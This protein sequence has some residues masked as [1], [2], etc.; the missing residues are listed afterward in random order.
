MLRQ[1]AVLIHR[2]RFEGVSVARAAR[3]IGMSRTTAYRWLKRFDDGSSDE[4]LF[5]RSR[6]PNNS[7]QRTPV[8][9]ERRI[10]DLHEQQGWPLAR[11]LSQLRT[12]GS[13][14]P[15]LST[16]RRILERHGRR[17]RRS[18]PKVARPWAELVRLLI[19]GTP[20]QDENPP[21]G[22]STSTNLEELVDIL[23]AG[24][25]RQRRRALVVLL[26]ALGVPRSAVVE[27]ARSSRQTVQRYRNEFRERGIQSIPKSCRRKASESRRSDCTRC[28]LWPPTLSPF[29]PRHQSH[30]LAYEGSEPH[31]AGTGYTCF[32]GT[33]SR[34]PPDWGL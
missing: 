4:A 13:P 32:N 6:R 12:E 16:A 19:W 14:A 10:L 9:I 3:E 34:N 8:R 2:V 25:V 1:R 24:G 26:L 7:P 11:I 31:S 27:V 17:P 30:Y 18:H 20:P 22:E 28:G 23:R 29:G 15:S 5:D 33:H 21:S